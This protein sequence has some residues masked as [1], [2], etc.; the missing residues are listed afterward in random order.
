[1][2]KVGF[3]LVCGRLGTWQENALNVPIAGDTP[4]Q[5]KSIVQQ[6]STAVALQWVCSMNTDRDIRIC[7]CQYVFLA[8][9]SG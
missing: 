3:C 5:P 9:E 8:A 4:R 7:A 2:P 1:M 6:R